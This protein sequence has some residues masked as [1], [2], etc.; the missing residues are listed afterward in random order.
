MS[1]MYI[2][3]AILMLGVMLMVHESGHFW[4]ARL[5]GIP[6]KQ[7]SIGLGPQLFSWKSKKYET[8]FFVRLIPAGGYCMFYGEDDAEGKEAREDPRSLGNYAAWKRMIAIFMGPA[9]NFILALV[10]AAAL[11]GLVGEDTLGY[12]TLPQITAVDEGSPAAIAG[13]LPGDRLETVNGE[14]AVGLNEDQTALRITDLINAY[15]PGGEALRLGVRR[16]DEQVTVS[17]SPQYSETEKRFLMG[18]KLQSGYVPVYTPV[19]VPRAMQLGGEYCVQAAGALI[20]GLR[21]MI[22]T[23]AGLE[24]SSGPVGI[25]KIIAEETQ[26]SAAES[27]R[28]ALITYGNLLVIISVNLGLFNLFP[29]PGLDGSRL[30]FL[31]IEIF[32]RKPVPQKVEAY[33]HLSGYVLL[34]GLMIVLTCKDIFQIFH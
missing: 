18:V 4:A 22:T 17:L 21:D 23:G 27:R 9:M 28:E 10:V 20:Q 30:V 5:T 16:G 14:S 34:F 12:Y 29:I 33:I 3:A 13:L 8:R 19:T 11:F 1:L 24:Q 15:Q 7:F 32:R 25:V 31:L 6:V 26:R 2:L